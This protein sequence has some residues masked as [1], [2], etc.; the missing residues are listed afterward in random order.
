MAYLLPICEFHCRV[1]NPVNG[2]T[3]ILPTRIG[4]G[5]GKAK[6]SAFV[7]QVARSAIA[8]ETRW[9]VLVCLV[10]IILGGF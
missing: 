5:E 10:V 7:A 3:S 9:G 4:S 2:S 8:S 1:T 6:L